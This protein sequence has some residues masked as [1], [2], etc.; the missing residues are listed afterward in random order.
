[1]QQHSMRICSSTCSTRTRGMYVRMYVISERESTL[2]Y[3]LPEFGKCVGVQTPPANMGEGGLYTRIS[4][5]QV[6]GTQGALLETRQ[7]TSEEL[8]G[9]ARPPSS[10]GGETDIYYIH[11]MYVCMYVGSNMHVYI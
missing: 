7:K 4:Q 1:M 9:A 10:E 3:L 11:S 8:R 6:A 5:V 2:A